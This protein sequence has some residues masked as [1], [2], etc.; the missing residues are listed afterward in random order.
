MNAEGP[1]GIGFSVKGVEK[2]KVDD[3][4]KAFEIVLEKEEV[5]QAILKESDYAAKLEIPEGEAYAHLKKAVEVSYSTSRGTIVVGLRGKVKQNAQLDEISQSIFEIVAPV[6]AQIKP[7]FGAH[8]Q[9]L[10]QGG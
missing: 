3:W 7:E 1:R 9:R 4:M 6:V 10:S 5:L 8:Y 2:E